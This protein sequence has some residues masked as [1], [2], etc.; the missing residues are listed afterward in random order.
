MPLSLRRFGLFS[1]LVV[2]LLSPVGCLH[3]QSAPA[4]VVGEL[5]GEMT[6]AGEVFIGGDVTL[7][8]DARLTIRPGT[9]V[10]FLGP[11]GF[12]GGE[13]EHPHFPGSELNIYGVLEAMGTPAQPIAF[14]AADDDAPAGSWGAVNFAEGSRGVLRYCVF[15]QADSAVHSREA[16]VEVTES[17][18]ENNLVGI[19]F[20]TSNMRIERNL[21]H[22]N[23]TGIRFHF[24]A[25]VVNRNR[26]EENRVNL[27]ITA[28]PRDY[29][30]EDNRFGRPLEYHVVLGEEVPE[31]VRL[32]N[33]DWDGAA[34]DDVTARIFD[35]RRSPY[36][37]TVGIE[38]LRVVPAAEAGPSWIR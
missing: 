21:L 7:A 24:G 1:L 3:R 13:S 34:V 29:R 5:H 22:G 30:F 23:D 15:R 19:R 31:D 38:P 33:N 35:G 9:V 20:H 26:F 36:L 2:I 28:H 6:W 37:G 27:F 4:V 17:R 14:A 12:A 10:R 8:A 11:V 32:S 16:T 25:P 18:F